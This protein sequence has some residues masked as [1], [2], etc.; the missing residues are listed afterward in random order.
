V[1]RTG[2]LRQEFIFACDVGETLL[3]L[4][5]H[6]RVYKIKEREECAE[7]V[8]ESC[9][10]IEITVT[11]LSVIWTVVNRFAGLVDFV[12]LAREKCCPVKA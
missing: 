11:D 7:C 6:R 9:V 10:C 5:I 2:P 12:E 4:L 1:S 8:P 3:N